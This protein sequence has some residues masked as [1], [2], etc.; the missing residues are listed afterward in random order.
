[1]S[2]LRLI[3]ISLL[4]F[5]LLVSG[6]AR[7]DVIN[8]PTIVGR[9]RVPFKTT[10]AGLD[11]YD[12]GT[13]TLAFGP[14]RFSGAVTF[15]GTMTFDGAVTFNGTATFNDPVTFNDTVTFTNA[16]E[17]PHFVSTVNSGS[18]V[19]QFGGT[20]VAGRGGISTSASAHLT[21]NSVDPGGDI[22]AQ[23]VDGTRTNV[24]AASLE[25]DA[26]VT[27]GIIFGT[28][29]AGGRIRSA[30]ASSGARIVI[31]S[32]IVDFESNG[33]VDYATFDSAPH[34]SF[35]GGVPTIGTCGTGPTVN[36]DSTDTAG[37]FT[38]GTGTP[39][40]CTITFN[41]AWP[42]APKCVITPTGSQ[43]SVPFINTITTALFTITQT[44]ADSKGYV[45]MCFRSV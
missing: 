7:S 31:G 45:Y 3:A 25:L 9:T 29:A 35:L 38:T 43:A 20:L 4:I 18:E 5:F 12:A 39:T 36:S 15:I 16:I 30:T 13:G 17:A 44:G 41:T 42:T 40:N 10:E 8:A 37:A 14:W 23:D 28:A 27:T 6:K 2:R 26:N 34:A 21:L 33:S 11:S 24:Q 32:N 22:I 1:M 19:L